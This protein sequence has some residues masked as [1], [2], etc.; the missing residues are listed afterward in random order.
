M[1]DWWAIAGTV[2]PLCVDRTLR[3]IVIALRRPIMGNPA[4]KAT[5]PASEG[6]R[7]YV[8]IC[9]AALVLM[10]PALFTGQMTHD[11]FWIDIVWADQFTAVLKSGTL[12]P[13]WLPWS[14]D[15]LGAPIFYFYPPL[16]FYLTALFGLLGVSTYGSLIAAFGTALAASGMSMFRW[17]RGW[18]E[19]PLLAALFYMAAPYHL[20]D[21]YRRGALAEFVA[22]AFIPLVAL[23]MKRAIVA[24]RPALLALAYAGL[25][26]THLPA[27][28]LTSVL[29]IAPWGALAALR[30]RRAAAPL[31]TGI[32]LGLGL[33]AL[34]LVPMQMMRGEVSTQYMLSI[35]QYQAA[36][37]SLVAP[38]RWPSLAGAK[39]LAGLCAIMIFPALILIAARR[40]DPW[41]WG[42]A[43]VCA[44][45][46]GLLP[47]FWSLPLIANTQFPW[48][49]LMLAEFLLATGFALTPMRPLLAALAITPM[50][51]LSAVLLKPV[52]ELDPTRP[53][54][55]LER[56]LDVRE[57]VPQ[58]APDETSWYAKWA[59]AISARHKT[60]IQDGAFTIAPRFYFPS[61]EVL[62]HGRKVPTAPDPETRL[63]RW[64]GSNSDCSARIGITPFELAGAGLSLLS[65]L[66]LVAV[67]R[68]RPGEV[69]HASRW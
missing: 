41:A 5:Q 9:A 10:L 17:L 22:F 20:M 3:T 32:G 61:W 68:R 38:D 6:W 12:Y 60:P 2:S 18:T 4:K 64:R 47:G 27:A 34:Y 63:L 28:L 45:A 62:C 57:Y 11:S 49:A 31:A 55:W 58:G 42:A 35:P 30:D 7:A 39:L 19:R 36:N 24:R 66:V 50:I 46:A 44:V 53:A 13:R 52:H 8:A 54:A 15:G 48:R 37:W 51:A 21:F 69:A 26:L 67:A 16:A 65:L 1:R 40:R 33:A 25:I 23:G 14:Y 56:H 43:A 59:M 29:L